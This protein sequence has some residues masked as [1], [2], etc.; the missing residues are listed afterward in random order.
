[1]SVSFNSLCDDFY[2]NM[3][4][5]TELEL[6]SERDTILHFFERI[7]RQYPAMNTFYQRESGDF[8]LDEDRESGSYCWIAVE[9]DRICSGFVNPESF[10]TADEL[11][12]L[13]LEL[14]PFT[15]GVNHL[16]I[17]SLDVMFGMD[18]DYQGNHDEIL[19]DALFQNSPFVSL[20]DLPQAKPLG[21]DPAILVSLSDDCRLQGRISLESR[22]GAYQVRTGKFKDEE[23]LSLY[24][25]I[26]QYPDPAS[27]F[28]SLAS[29]DDQRQMC[30]EI[31]TDRVIPS[32]VNPIVNAIAQ[33]R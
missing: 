29:Y 10:E 25:S 6:P 21:F 13:I 24:L 3:T 16:D 12:K 2:V 33:R 23:Q 19:A 27:R 7:Q 15:L 14:A 32:F 11:N 17:N 8:C 20:L 5:N 31:M 26:R 28:N 9:K 30:V 18:F 4:L 22:T 1:M